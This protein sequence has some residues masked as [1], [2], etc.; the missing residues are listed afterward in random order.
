MNL[1]KFEKSREFYRIGDSLVA[2]KMI[3]GVLTRVKVVDDDETS[4]FCEKWRVKQKRPR[5]L[6]VVRSKSG[7]IRVS[8]SAF[9]MPDDLLNELVRLVADDGYITAESFPNID[10][11]F[12]KWL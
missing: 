7:H 3:D 10:K 8:D 11:R 9:S 1:I 5:A 2:D 4:F 12:E 6:G